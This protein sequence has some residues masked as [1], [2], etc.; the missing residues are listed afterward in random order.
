MT[1]A[2]KLIQ[3]GVEEGLEQG[4][5][6]GLEKGLEQGLER[7]RTEERRHLLL[8]LVESRFG[9][10]SPSRIERIRSASAGELGQ[11][12][13]RLLTAGSLDELLA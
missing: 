10:P 11:W 1:T 5:Q 7:G 12:F 9:E 4:L 3:Q 6:K 2:E 8:R 13:D